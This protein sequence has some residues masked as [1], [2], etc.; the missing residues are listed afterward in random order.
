MARYR[1]VR[2]NLKKKLAKFYKAKAKRAS[3]S[4]TSK[5]GFLHVPGELRNQIY[6]MVLLF[7]VKIKVSKGNFSEPA[8]LSTCHQIRK[9]TMKIYYI[10]NRWEIDCPDWDYS[11]R[12]SFLQTRQVKARYYEFEGCGHELG[13]QWQSDQ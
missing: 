4:D 2:A 11:V 6:R 13:Q 7:E 3:T 5:K 9:E 12:Q 10:E 8:L 1:R